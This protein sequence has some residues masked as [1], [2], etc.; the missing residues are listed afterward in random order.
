MKGISAVPPTRFS[1]ELWDIFIW[2][3]EYCLQQ[4]G[5]CMLEQ[6]NPC[7]PIK[8]QYVWNHLQIYLQQD[9][10]HRLPIK[11]DHSYITSVQVF[12]YIIDYLQVKLITNT[13]AV[14]ATHV[15][16]CEMSY[17]ICPIFPVFQS[18]SRPISQNIPPKKKEGHLL[19]LPSSHLQS[20]LPA[21]QNVPATVSRRWN[22]QLVLHEVPGWC[23]WVEVIGMFF[24]TR[25]KWSNWQKSAGGG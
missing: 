10:K 5:R 6:A 8:S 22:H 21:T 25:M 12:I 24:Q 15:Y 16:T 7:M 13:A 9:R 1:V 14:N 2:Y 23:R 3:G 4:S 11:M 18:L 20:T 17:S 19:L